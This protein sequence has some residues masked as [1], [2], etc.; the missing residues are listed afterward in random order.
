MARTGDT[1][2]A[3]EIIA[4]HPGL[5]KDKALYRIAREEFQSGAKGS[6]SSAAHMWR[7][8]WRRAG[9]AKPYVKTGATALARQMIAEAPEIGR[10]TDAYVRTRE[11]FYERADGSKASKRSTWW[12]A[13]VEAGIKAPHPTAA[14]RP[15]SKWAQYSTPGCAGGSGGRG[16]GRLKHLEPEILEEIGRLFAEGETMRWSAEIAGV[17][18]ETIKFYFRIFANDL[19]DADEMPK[20]PCGLPRTHRGFCA[21]RAARSPARQQAL[22]N[23][24][25]GH[26][27]S[28][29]FFRK[30]NAINRMDSGRRSL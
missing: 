17:P 26:Q 6:K 15:E 1:A 19:T 4:A 14:H 21:H 18:L 7:R 16:G 11:S 27:G 24:R 30:L 22:K 29:H 9:F 10:D 5:E 8:E 2:L 23:I 28:R 3:R 12:R 13:V 25:P 20:C